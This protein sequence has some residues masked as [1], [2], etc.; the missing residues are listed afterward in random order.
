MADFVDVL[1]LA[2]LI[3]SWGLDPHRNFE[4]IF[5]ELFDQERARQANELQEAIDRLVQAAEQLPAL[6][7][8]STIICSCA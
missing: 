7:Q 4:E 1:G 3:Q 2:P 6:R 5:S 8:L